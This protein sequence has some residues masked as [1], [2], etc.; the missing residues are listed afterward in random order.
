MAV[1][2]DV[3]TL[4]QKR[5]KLKAIQALKDGLPHL[6]SFPM[7]KWQEEF[8]NCGA[9]FQFIFKANQI[10]GSSVMIKK[11]IDYCTNKKLWERFIRPPRMTMYLYP[12]KKSATREWENKWA[13]FMPRN[14]Y[15][16]HPVYGWKETWDGHYIDSIEWNSGLI[17][18]FKTYGSG[19]E[20]LQ[21]STP[22]ILACDEELPEEL[23][24]E[25]QMRI[26]SPANKGAMYWLGCTPTIG[27]KYLAKIQSG[28]TKIPDS[29]VKTV[30][31]YDCLEYASGDKS[32]WS[33]EKIK[34]IEQTLPNDKEVQVRVHGLFKATEGL[35]I[36]QFD[37]KRHVKPYHPV[38]GWEIYA[39]L[40]YGVGGATGHPSSIVFVAVS[41]NYNAAR[42]IKAWRGPFGPN[43]DSTTPDDVILKY[44]EMCREIGIDQ[45][46]AAY[47][48]HAAA[49]LGVLADRQGMSFTKANKDK[50]HGTDLLNSLFKND[51]LILL[52]DGQDD[53]ACLAEELESVTVDFNKKKAGD[54][55]T[56]ALRYS[57]SS[58][59]F[60]FENL[61][62]QPV[63]EVAQ[64]NVRM[65][66]HTHEQDYDFDE[67]E[68]EID[69]W[70]ELY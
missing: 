26:S 17:T 49:S 58:I 2:S 15:K 14:E 30:S 37:S 40:D 50:K 25:L 42:V 36:S 34:Q 67:I 22:A 4:K 16:D 24:P 32:I 68:R 52:T 41:P 62:I 19:A 8:W 28:E 64:S 51:M 3:K 35:L 31:M 29:W 6:Y 57:T 69:E 38:K 66:R 21:A 43:S 13:E 54:D 1:S 55:L 27:Q 56:D 33:T 59:P 44:L 53:V 65:G 47:Y 60:N 9:T 11:M 10:G 45:P 12:D 46:T 63:T 7:Y 23:W 39:G 61:K 5:D 20:N 70:N 48:D 18:Y